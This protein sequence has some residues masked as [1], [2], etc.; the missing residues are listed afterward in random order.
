MLIVGKKSK[1]NDLSFKSKYRK[2]IMNMRAEINEM[3]NKQERKSKASVVF[4]KDLK[5]WLNSS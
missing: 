1:S 2:E 3:G 4:Y 5:N